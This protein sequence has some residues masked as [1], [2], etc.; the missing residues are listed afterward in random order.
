MITDKLIAKH[1]EDNPSEL[2]WVL[3]SVGSSGSPKMEAIL[4]LLA[5]K[6]NLSTEVLAELLPEIL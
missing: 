1:I 5:V 3:A 6:L 4:N 2:L